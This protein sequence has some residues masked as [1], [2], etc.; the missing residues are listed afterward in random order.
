VGAMGGLSPEFS[1]EKMLPY[2]D[3]PSCYSPSYRFHRCAQRHRVSNDFSHGEEKKIFLGIKGVRGR[4]KK[5]KL[6]K[7]F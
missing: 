7:T 1:P 2:S 5:Q 3:F 4:K 6:K